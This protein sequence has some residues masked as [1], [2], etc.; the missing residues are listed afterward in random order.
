MHI[1]KIRKLIHEEDIIFSFSGQV[2]QALIEFIIAI[3]EEKLA[4]QMDKVDMKKLFIVAIEQLQNVINN[5]E[6]CG[7]DCSCIGSEVFIIGYDKIKEKYYVNTANEIVESHKEKISNKID[8]INS[9]NTEQ[10]RELLKAKL[11]SAE[12]LHSRGAGVGLIE[13]SKRSSE[14]I[15][16]NFENYQNKLYFQI[17]VYI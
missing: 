9:L 10:Q 3:T 15:E 1:S 7:R 2:S 14:K 11:K 4:T 8:Y 12:D 5:A 17:L 16:Y 6:Y 13:M